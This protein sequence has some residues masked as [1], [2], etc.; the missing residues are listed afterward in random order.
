MRTL[1]L[2]ISLIAFLNIN[3]QSNS[4]IQEYT[5]RYI[6]PSGSIADDAI[7]SLVNDTTLM[8]SATVG[9]SELK[10]IKKDIFTL[11]QYGGTITFVRTESENEIKGFKITIPMAGIDSLE[12]QK[13]IQTDPIDNKKQTL[14]SPYL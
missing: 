8:I 10:C 13:E 12:A 4:N 7:I 5:G 3:A 1:L 11:P 2:F 9:E 6:F 14:A